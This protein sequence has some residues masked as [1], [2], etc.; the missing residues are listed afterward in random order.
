MITICFIDVP[1]VEKNFLAKRKLILISR[2]LRKKNKT[3]QFGQFGQS[4]TGNPA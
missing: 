1:I 2:E 4:Q 3:E